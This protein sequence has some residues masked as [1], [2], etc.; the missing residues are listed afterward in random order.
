MMHLIGCF[1]SV[2]V[3]A[4]SSSA[5]PASAAAPLIPLDD[6]AKAMNRPI[7]PFRISD[8]ITYVGTEDLG[9][10]LIGTSAGDILIDAGYEQTV[11]QILANLKTVGVDPKD[12]HIL[13]NSHSHVDHAGGLAALKKITGAKL[14]VSRAAADELARGGHDDP[15]FANRSIYP[16]VKAD[17]IVG[18]GETVVFGNVTLTAHLTPGHTKGCTTWTMPAHIAGKTYQALFLCSVTA[19]GYKLV[20]NAGYPDIVTDYR[21]SFAV[22][23]TLPCEIFLGSHARFYDMLR[24]RA[25]MLKTGSRTVFV[26]PSG[27]RRHLDEAEAAFDKAVAQQTR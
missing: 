3:L 9:I 8:E 22:L 1:L 24:K 19:P 18:D 16:P 2:I 10:Y 27:C 21:H 7:A 14:V 23:K 12:I 20:G 26:D 11:P 5:C 17:R 6:A 13:L 25:E 4:A 15:N